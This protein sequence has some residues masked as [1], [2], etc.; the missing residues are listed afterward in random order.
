MLCHDV[1]TCPCLLAYKLMLTDAPTL[2]LKISK[3]GR[4]KINKDSLSKNIFFNHKYLHT[5]SQ[6]NILKL[7]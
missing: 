2:Y 1:S 7:T 3:I 4:E 5:M 6:L